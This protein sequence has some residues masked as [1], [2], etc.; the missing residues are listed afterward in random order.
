MEYDNKYY[1]NKWVEVIKQLPKGGLYRFDLRKH[2]YQIIANYI[3]KDK[4]VFDYACGLGIIGKYLH[5]TDLYGCDFSSVAVEFASQFGKFEV[6]NEVFGSDYNFVIAS[7]FLE[8][9]KEPVKWINDA[10]KK[11]DNVICSIPN[12]FRQ[13]GE[14]IDMQWNSWESFNDLFKEF[15]IKR[16][17]VLN[18][19]NLY[20][21]DIPQAFKH[22]IV[23]F[24][25]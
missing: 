7:Y 23:E 9:T 22:P 25:R 1:D 21:N 19:K 24:T 15:K 4:K 16:L 8:H 11:S 13:Q 12:D 10:L 14:H 5:N 3:G 18:D 2:S 6:S 20:P 17:D